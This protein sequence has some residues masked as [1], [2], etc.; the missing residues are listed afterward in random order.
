MLE[1]CQTLLQENPGALFQTHLN[2]NHDEIREVARQF[3]WAGDYLAVYEKFG[4]VGA[5]SVLAHNVHPTE[6]E[7]QRLALSGGAV[8]HCPCS[9]AALGSGLFGMARHVAHGIR[10]TLGTDVGAGTG[11]GMLKEGLQA[12]LLQQISPQGFALTPA[13]LLYLATRAGAEA[14]GM[15]DAGDLTVGNSADFVHVK[16][17]EGSVLA[18]VV[19]NA[20]SAEHVLASLFTLAGTQN[21]AGTFVRGRVVYEEIR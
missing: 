16:P 1:V 13:H 18:S 2:E 14:L 19:R 12:Y 17:R 20:R 5:R 6:S 9:N 3:P 7:L 15:H 10:V 21:I 4:L 11:F 8:A